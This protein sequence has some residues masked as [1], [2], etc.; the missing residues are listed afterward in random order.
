MREVR[1][2]RPDLLRQRST[3]FCREGRFP[4]QCQDATAQTL[5][6]SGWV[7]KAFKIYWRSFLV[8]RTQTRSRDKKSLMGYSDFLE[9]WR[10]NF[11]K[12][13]SDSRSF[14]RGL[15]LFTQ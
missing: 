15:S 3:A 4:G 12:E 5:T 8:H 2:S 7:A 13:T 1:Q 6:C 9:T 10:N 11:Q 14:E